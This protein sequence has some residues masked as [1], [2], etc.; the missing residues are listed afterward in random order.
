MSYIW[1]GFKWSIRCYWYL[2]TFRW[3]KAWQVWRYEWPYE[4]FVP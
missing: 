2:F 1:A 3:A 4:R